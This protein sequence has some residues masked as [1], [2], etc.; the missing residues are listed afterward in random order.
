MEGVVAYLGLLNGLKPSYLCFKYLLCYVEIL[1][2]FKLG[3]I[4]QRKI[5]QPFS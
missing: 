5:L 3:Y 2:L 4:I 1:F